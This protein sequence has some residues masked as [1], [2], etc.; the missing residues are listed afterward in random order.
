MLAVGK[1]GSKASSK[2]ETIPMNSPLGELIKKCEENEYTKELSQFIMIKYCVKIWPKKP[3]QEGSV[4]WPWY[5]SKEWWLCVALN[6]YLSTRKNLNEEEIKYAVFWLK[7]SS[8]SK[9]T[10]VLKL[11]KELEDKSPKSKIKKWD[12]LDHLPPQ[13][14]LPPPLSMIPLSPSPPPMVQTLPIPTPVLPALT[15]SVPPPPLPTPT[16]PAPPTPL[17]TPTTPV[18]TP[19]LLTTQTPSSAPTLASSPVIVTPTLSA[20]LLEQGETIGKDETPNSEQCNSQVKTSHP[21]EARSKSQSY[22]VE[23]N[24]SYLYPLREV[25]MGGAL[26]G[27]GFINT[28]LRASEVRGFKKEIKRSC[29]NCQPT[30]SISWAQYLYM[31]RAK[32]NFK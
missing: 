24:A 13:N 6:R 19:I 30:R 22:Q 9:E 29:G 10:K 31:G 11:S 4:Y 32:F 7:F 16:L 15:P 8:N 3:I 23:S 21:Y 28:P 20:S 2:T 12:P 1:C 25:P 18:P 26:G 27:I 17:L 5:G 14:P